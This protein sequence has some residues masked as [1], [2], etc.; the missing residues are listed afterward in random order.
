MSSPISSISITKQSDLLLHFLMTENWLSRSFGQY[1]VFPYDVLPKEEAITCI[2]L[3][4]YENRTW[5]NLLNFE[6][7]LVLVVTKAKSG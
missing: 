6:L 4:V 7:L 2:A 5:F 3:L 1:S